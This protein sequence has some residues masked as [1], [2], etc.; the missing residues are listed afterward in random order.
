MNETLHRQW[1][2]LSMIPRE[3][4]K[5][6]VDDIRSR[7][8]GEGYNVTVRTIQRDLNALSVQFPL[9]SDT[10]NKPYGWSWAR[11]AR[12]FDV[13]GMDAE[14][15]LTFKLAEMFLAPA[16]PPAMHERLKP[17]FDQADRM[18]KP[19]P[20]HH[21]TERVRLIPRGQP[22]KAPPIR[23]A[24]VQAVYEALLN[25][26]RLEIRYRSRQSPDDNAREAEISPLGLVF[27][28]SVAYLVCGFWDYP[29]IRT[30]ALHR[31]ERAKLLDKSATEP[32]DFDLDAYIGGGVFDLPVG[33]PIRLVARFTRAAAYH[34]QEG[35]L[36]DDQVLKPLEDDWVRVEA[37]VSDTA[38][39]RWWL[40]GFGSQVEVQ[41]PI[42]LRRE[43]AK[44]ASDMANLY[45]A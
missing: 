19:S 6:S 3:P 17:H 18:L 33:P 35:G 34:L 21:W 23:K 36:S 37:T 40:L 15:A 42:R 1:C 22:L 31:V 8:N 29:D 39:L 44:I 38:Q 10:R 4:R 13:P 12:V 20:L 14:T 45:I 30:L 26:Q 2:M 32:T 24:V 25:Q 11:D 41:K 16:L 27:R 43:L 28:E 7:L 5:L 9:V